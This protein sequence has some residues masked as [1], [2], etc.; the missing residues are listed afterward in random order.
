MCTAYPAGLCIPCA[1]STSRCAC[2]MCFTRFGTSTAESWRVVSA[3]APRVT[4]NNAFRAAPSAGD[5]PVLA[6]CLDEI[7]AAARLKAAEGRQQRANAYS[8]T[9]D[10]QNQ[11]FGKQRPQPGD[12]GGVSADLPA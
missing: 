8:I 7:L 2:W 9:L 3:P 1:R 6:N 10:A 5:R 4:S 11:R 12:H